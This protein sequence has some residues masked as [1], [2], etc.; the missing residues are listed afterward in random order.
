MSNP[1]PLFDGIADDLFIHTSTSPVV[2]LHFDAAW[3][4][5][6]RKTRAALERLR[7]KAPSDIRL[8]TIDIDEERNWKLAVRLGVTNVPYIAIYVD[9]ELFRTHRYLQVEPLEQDVRE[10]L[11]ATPWYWRKKPA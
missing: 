2:V 7:E 6:I 11:R 4:N 9:G 3:N 5:P 1:S 10:A 8:L